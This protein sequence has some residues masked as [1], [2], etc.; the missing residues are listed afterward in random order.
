MVDIYQ[1]ALTKINGVGVAIARK[2]IETF[3][4]A[5][6]FFKESPSNLKIIFGSRDRIIRQIVN[7]EMFGRCEQELEFIQKYNIHSYFFTDED[8]PMRLKQ[9]PDAPIC[10][11][12]QGSGNIDAQRVVAV[13][14]TRKATDYG[15]FITENIISHLQDLGATVVS[16]LA[17]GIDSYAHTSCLNRNM[18]TFGIM[19]TGLDDVY[20]KEHFDLAQRMKEQGGLITEYFTKTP[21]SAYNFPAR[22][23]IIAGLCD[24]VIVVEAAKKGGA[25]LTARLANDYNREVIAVPG[26][27]ADEYSLGC[28]FLIENNRAHILSDFNSI[29]KL[30]NWN[31]IGN[32][33]SKPLLN[34]TANDKGSRLQGNEK[35]VYHTIKQEPQMD[36][37]TLLIKTK[38][39][40]SELSA[41]LLNL[42]LLNCIIAKPG[43]VY[44][45][46]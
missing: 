24:L 18:P 23:R 17:Y 9:I 46:L 6:A 31:P 15:R 5:E 22:N 36:M 13:V 35:L 16:G 37:D 1:L 43:K 44:K 10:L 12:M 45:A 38:L 34:N 20:P 29:D 39:N 41:I 4:S 30:M 3:S 42:E 26:R 11:F 7:K 27:Y 28:N 40:Y 33:Q 8:Y 19:G 14:G 21:P 32:N 2:I 25:L